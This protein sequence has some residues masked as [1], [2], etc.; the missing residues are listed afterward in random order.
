M[1]LNDDTETNSSGNVVPFTP[2]EDTYGFIENTTSF[3]PDEELLEQINQDSK[4]AELTDTEYEVLEHGTPLDVVSFK[5]VFA[6]CTELFLERRQQ[7]GNHLDNARRFPQENQSGIY[8]KMSR[9]IRDIENGTFKEDTLK[10]LINYLA[11]E[12]T[13]KEH[14]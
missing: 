6:D 10:D 14:V 3:E 5:K 13:I 12:L 7:Y 8:L 1:W 11:M 4:N 2:D 9:A